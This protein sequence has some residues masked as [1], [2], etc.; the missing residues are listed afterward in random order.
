VPSKYVHILE[1][2]WS[3]YDRELKRQRCKNLQRLELPSAFKKNL[4]LRRN[5]LGYYN[6]AAVVVN[7]EAVCRIGPWLRAVADLLSFMY[8]Q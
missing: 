3:R 4:L 8:L 2:I 6:A 1:P 5:G 7:S